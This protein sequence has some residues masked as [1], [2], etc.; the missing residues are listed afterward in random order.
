[1]FEEFSHPDALRRPMLKWLLLSLAVILI[2]AVLISVFRYRQQSEEPSP[3]ETPLS[4]EEQDD[5]STPPA[6]PLSPEQQSAIEERIQ[7]E[8]QPVPLSSEQQ[9]AI[10]VRIQSDTAAAPLSS[11]QKSM[12]EARIKGN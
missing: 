6:I 1:M 5:G 9:S 4:S 12:I 7:A 11:E 3:Q 2:A 10:E 8:S